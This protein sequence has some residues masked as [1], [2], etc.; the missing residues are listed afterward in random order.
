METSLHRQ[1]KQLYARGAAPQEVVLDDFRIDVVVDG[2]LIEIQHGGL[3]AIRDKIRRLVEQHDVLVVKPLVAS[4]TIVKLDRAGGRVVSRR[5]SPKQAQPLDLFHELTYFTRCFPHPR[6]TLDVP[7]VAIEEWRYPGHGRRRRWRESDH[8]VED[9][10]LIE[11]QQTLRLK[12]DQDLLALLPAPLPAPFDSAVVAQLA[13]V[14]RWVAQRITYC[15]RQ[16]GIAREVGKI[17]NTRQ[18]ELTTPKKTIRRRRVGQASNAS[19]GPPT[20]LAKVRRKAK[21]ELAS[22]RRVGQASEASA[23][24]PTSLP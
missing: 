16:M 13:G 18:Y 20:T 21:G 24:P 2:Q 1:L 19:A 15:L 7:L 10:R 11:V 3:A 17:G 23:G 14:P 5:R 8:V 4:K 6:L 22:A 9:Q 12:T